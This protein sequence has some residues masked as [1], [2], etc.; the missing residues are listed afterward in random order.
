MG[1]RPIPNHITTYILQFYNPHDSFCHKINY[2]MTIDTSDF[3]TLKE[4]FP[5]YPI[6]EDKHFF[7]TIE[8]FKDIL[9]QFFTKDIFNKPDSIHTRAALYYVSHIKDCHPHVNSNSTRVAKYSKG[10]SGWFQMQEERS[11]SN[12][13]RSWI[14]SYFL[15]FTFHLQF[16]KRYA[17]SLFLQN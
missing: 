2:Y 13:P 8:E 15:L 17:L 5:S 10:S 6:E 4:M 1:P 16:E 11:H 14:C 7:I 9:K 12:S 3:R